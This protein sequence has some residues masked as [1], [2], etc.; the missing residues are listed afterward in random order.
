MSETT[1]PHDIEFEVASQREWENEY[2]EI[3]ARAAAI[4]T[5]AIIMKRELTKQ[6]REFIEMTDAV[7]RLE[8]EEAEIPT[9]WL[10]PRCGTINAPDVRRCECEPGEGDLR[11][12]ILPNTV[13]G[14]SETK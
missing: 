9:G 6:E 5:D 3:V 2:A 11:H 10:C 1:A 14:P 12:G 13:V 8:Y 4:K 7:A